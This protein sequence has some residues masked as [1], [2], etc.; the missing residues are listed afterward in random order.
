MKLYYCFLLVI[1]TIN[2]SYANTTP[3][4]K[5]T[6]QTVFQGLSEQQPAV[7][8]Q[9]LP[10]SYQ[11]QLTRLIQQS[12]S[13][14]NP[15]VHRKFIQLLTKTKKVLQQKQAFF[16]NNP[17]IKS[18]P[19]VDK[20]LWQ[21]IIQTLN[22]LLAS[23][24]TDI[25]YLKN[26]NLETLLQSTGQELSQKLHLFPTELSKTEFEV[27]ESDTQSAQVKISYPN[28]NSEVLAFAL[29]ENKWLPLKFIEKWNTATDE[30]QQ[31]LQL[32]PNPQQ[33]M[34]AM[35]L[36]NTVEIMLVQLE[37][38]NSQTE[39][40]QVFDQSLKNINALGNQLTE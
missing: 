19:K 38:I 4:I 40:D 24:L 1:L 9:A 30:M 25:N 16:L 32:G 20:A 13:Q 29:I 17:D 27:L 11:Q 3:D 26:I 39:F 12:A 18:H 15:L 21:D 36:L 37:K 34:I 6:L 5:Q 28:Q 33:D 31:Y 35:L 22:I 8:W 2:S 7:L 23:R 10:L 14:T